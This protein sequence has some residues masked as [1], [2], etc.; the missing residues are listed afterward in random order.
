ME[1]VCPEHTVQETQDSLYKKD[2]EWHKEN[3]NKYLQKEIYKKYLQKRDRY[4]KQTY[5]YQKEM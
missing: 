2:M 3:V 1:E 4:W 5:S